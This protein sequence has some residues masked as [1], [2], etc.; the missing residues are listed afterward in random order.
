M[1]HGEVRVS[2]NGWRGAGVLLALALMTICAPAAEAKSLYGLVIGINDYLGEK[3]DLEGALNDANDIAAGLEA[4]KAKRIVKLLDQDASKDAILSNYNALVAEAQPG[5]TLVVSFSGHGSQE[6]EPPDRHGEA[7]GKNENLLLANYATKGPGSKERILDDEIFEWLKVAD[8]K[9]VH[10]VLAVDSCHS[11]TMTRGIGAGDPVRY[12]NADLGPITD[13]QLDFPP[14]EYA[15]ATEA[16]FKTVTFVG[17]TTDDKLVPEVRIEGQWRGALSWAFA[18]ALEGHGDRNH[19]GVLTEFELISYLVPAVH[20]WVESQQTPQV[21]PLRP[22][23]T[24]LFDVGKPPETQLV[25]SNDTG[26]DAGG[27]L[28]RKATLD[29][30]QVSISGGDVS[31]EGLAFVENASDAGS[32]DLIFDAGSGKLDSRVGGVVAEG[33]DADSVK[34]VIAKFA[35]LKWL[36]LQSAEA[37]VDAKVVSGDQRYKPGEKVKVEM[38]QPAHPFLTLFNMPPDGKVEFF[39]PSADDPVTS[40]KDW[41]TG[42]PF[43]SEFKVDQPPYGAEHLVAIYTDEPLDGLVQVMPD[44]TTGEKALPLLGLLQ[45]SLKDRP[46][47][48]A[49]VGIYTGE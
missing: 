3:N 27:P 36:R 9:G 48:A 23:E 1:Q 4:A 28:V 8:G 29:P 12:R 13:D 2:A 31:L 43:S 32:A 16:D 10:V 38:G 41:R 42:K 22:E 6:P 7:D 17:A 35:V 33:L 11:G 25:A 15:S 20:A 21:L 19:D 44:M 24:P 39:L 40:A 5:D 14:P 26:G 47:E 30:L 45:Q 46:F 34:P 49:I 37:G 18:R